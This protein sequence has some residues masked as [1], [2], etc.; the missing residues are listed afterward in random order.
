MFCNQT[1]CLEQV[2]L[3]DSYLGYYNNKFRPGGCTYRENFNVFSVPSDIFQAL[4][5]RF[6]LGYSRFL[7]DYLDSLFTFHSNI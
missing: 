7:P 4:C 1:Q 2:A 6:K 3:T 5:L